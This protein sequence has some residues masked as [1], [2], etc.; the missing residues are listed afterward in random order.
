MGALQPQLKAAPG[1]SSP[2]ALC[3]PADS[4]LAAEAVQAF[5]QDIRAWGK[6]VLMGQNPSFIFLYHGQFLMESL[7]LVLL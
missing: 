5:L 2:A 6:H 1:Q 3:S 4:F 7:E